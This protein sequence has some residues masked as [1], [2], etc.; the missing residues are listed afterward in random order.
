MES[1]VSDRSKRWMAIVSIPII[2]YTL[3]PILWIISMSMKSTATLA[4]GSFFPKDL[5]FDN[6]RLILTGD[7]RG[8]FLPAL[9]NSLVVC[10]TATVISVIL[11]MFAACCL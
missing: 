1:H 9:G 7:A 4:D 2:I 11:A 10:L 5:S 6:Y 3:I 8:L